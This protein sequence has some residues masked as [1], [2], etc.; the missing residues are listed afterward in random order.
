MCQNWHPE[1][2][3]LPTTLKSKPLETKGFHLG[4]SFL[5]HQFSWV[6]EL[7]VSGSEGLTW[8]HLTL[9]LAQY[10][11]SSLPFQLELHLHLVAT[12]QPGLSSAGSRQSQSCSRKTPLKYPPFQSWQPSRELSH[13]IPPNGKLGKSSTQK[14]RER[15][16]RANVERVA[17]FQEIMLGYRLKKHMSNVLWCL[18]VMNLLD[19]DVGLDLSKNFVSMEFPGSLKRW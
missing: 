16:V 15:L 14:C 12:E 5:N 4:K 13:A 18:M 6:H 10:R 7:F 9:P 17:L 8:H 3:M 19:E 1:Y 11:A 2:W